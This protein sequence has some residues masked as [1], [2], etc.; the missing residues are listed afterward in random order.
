METGAG[1]FLIAFDSLVA[2]EPT[3][4]VARIDSDGLVG[5]KKAW[6]E[7]WTTATKRSPRF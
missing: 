3:V 6:S 5:E 4:T 1:R 2:N 7:R